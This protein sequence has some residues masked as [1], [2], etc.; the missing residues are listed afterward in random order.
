MRKLLPV[1]LVLAF[2]LSLNAAAQTDPPHRNHLHRLRSPSKPDRLP[3]TGALA[4]SNGLATSTVPL[5]IGTAATTGP[6][7]QTNTCAS[8]VAAGANCT[9]SITFTP[10]ATGSQTGAFTITDSDFQS[11]QTVTLTGTGD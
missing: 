7:A 8:S 3:P 11:P 2:V 4:A 5:V 10:T 9:V 6:F 1:I